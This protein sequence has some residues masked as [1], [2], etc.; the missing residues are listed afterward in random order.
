MEFDPMSWLLG[1]SAA[2]LV[3][4]RLLPKIP[5]WFFNVLVLL[6]AAAAAIWLILA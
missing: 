4:V 2:M 6:L 5:Q 3:G 1:A